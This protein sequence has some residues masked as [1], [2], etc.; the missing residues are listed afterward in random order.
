MYPIH[1]PSPRKLMNPTTQPLHTSDYI[2][3]ST[4]LFC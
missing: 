4:I 2:I 3:I 1:L